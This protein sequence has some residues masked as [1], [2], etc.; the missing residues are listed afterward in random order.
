MRRKIFSCILLITLACL[1]C[2]IYVEDKHMAY[3]GNSIF[4][5][6]VLPNDMIVIR[7]WSDDYNRWLY[8]FGDFRGEFFDGEKSI[9]V[10]N[11]PSVP[12]IHLSMRTILSYGYKKDEMIIHWLGCD[13]CEY[14][15]KFNPKIGSYCNI[16]PSQL[17][18]EEEVNKEEY[19]WISLPAK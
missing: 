9:L 19:T 13:S 12:S 7:I 8:T 6:H 14:F 5:H 18:K 10:N 17:I 11:G 3:Y 1:S 2:I 16:S 4:T 15:T